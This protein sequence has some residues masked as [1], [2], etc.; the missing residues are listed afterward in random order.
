MIEFV[1]QSLEEE[2]F[3]KRG[4]LFQLFIEQGRN[5]C[6]NLRCDQVFILA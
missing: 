5:V 6:V 1:L 4:L 3:P 2:S